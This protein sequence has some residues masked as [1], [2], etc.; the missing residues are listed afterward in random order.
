MN[1]KIT[2][3]TPVGT[4]QQILPLTPVIVPQNLDLLDV[5]KVM[6]QH[7]KIDLAAVVNEQQQL[8]GLL[9]LPELSKDLFVHVFPEEFLSEAHDL[10]HAMEFARLT[11]IRTAGDAMSPALS[12]HEKDTVK[13]AF[14]QM[15]KHQLSGI[16]IV[17]DQQQVTGYI[18]RLDLLDLYIQAIQQLEKEKE[19]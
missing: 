12:I 19:Q 16:P 8:V 6:V 5:A 18:N 13:H 1:T 9:P 11:A 15:H 17:N 14:D 10:E 4:I 3:N 7:P 2:R